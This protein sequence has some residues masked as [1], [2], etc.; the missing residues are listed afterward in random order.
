MRPRVIQA[1]PATFD[2]TAENVCPGDIV[3]DPT[4]VVQGVWMVARGGATR[5]TQALFPVASNVR[6]DP[7]A[8]VAGGAGT[9]DGTINGTVI[10]GYT[11]AVV[12]NA[13]VRVNLI[14]SGAITAIT[15]STGTLRGLV[16]SGDNATVDVQATAAGL[17]SLA[18]NGTTAESLDG[19]VY[20]VAPSA[21]N[22]GGSDFSAMLP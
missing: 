14:S 8:F 2:A 16:I 12:P 19:Y 22:V 9:G 15:A 10:N 17:F 18:F 3:L 5:A 1:N 4:G 7:I 21:I 13:L 11:A 20:P 6:V